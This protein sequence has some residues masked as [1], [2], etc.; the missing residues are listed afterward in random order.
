MVKIESTLIKRREFLSKI[1][2]SKND[3]INKEDSGVSIHV[4][5]HGKGYQYYKKS[6]GGIDYIRAEDSDYVRELV[7][8]EYDRK[9]L[10]AAEKRIKTNK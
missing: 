2:S 10:A 8:N 9:V 5:S 7:Q 4:R 3:A 6:A 1:I